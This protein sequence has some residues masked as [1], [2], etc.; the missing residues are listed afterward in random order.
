LLTINPHSTLN[1]P[2]HRGGANRRQACAKAWLQQLSLTSLTRWRSG[3]TSARWSALSIPGSKWLA[4]ARF[5]CIMWSSRKA[6]RIHEGLSDMFASPFTRIVRKCSGT[7]ALVILAAFPL[8]AQSPPA[9]DSLAIQANSNRTPAGK[10]NGGVLTLHLELRQADWYPEADTGPS[11]KVFA[12][13]EE[14]KP[15]QVP[16]PMIRVPRGVEIHVT[17][18]NLLPTAAV[19]HGM[20]QHPG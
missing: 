13:S 5:G 14:G 9:T 15:P 12:F 18:R 6:F 17:L 3:L 8:T 2:R 7:V 1:P 16:G 20:H 10:L 4:R 19:V 11:M